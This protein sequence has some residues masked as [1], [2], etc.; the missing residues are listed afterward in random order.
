MDEDYVICVVHVFQS[1]DEA[2]AKHHALNQPDLEIVP[3]VEQIRY[4]PTDGTLIERT[5][6]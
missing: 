2:A 3:L 5:I 6:Q 1:F 4:V